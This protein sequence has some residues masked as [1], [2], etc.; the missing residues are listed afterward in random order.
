MPPAAEAA[1]RS[2]APVRRHRAQ[3]VR[4]ARMTSA[5]AVAVPGIARPRTRS[6]PP[7][8][9]SAPRPQPGIAESL[10]GVISSLPEHRF[11]DRLMRGRLWIGIVAFSLIGIVA[12][13]LAILDLNTGIGRSLAKVSRL[14]RENPAMSI[15]N[16]TAAAGENVEP[17]ATARGMEMSSVATM[18][19]LRSSPSNIERAAQILRE[20]A[21]NA[22]A[23][24]ATQSSTAASTPAE[25]TT[26]E[27]AA[28]SAPAPSQ[29]ENTASGTS[30]TAEATTV[31]TASESQA[32]TTPPA[33]PTNSPT[34]TESPATPASTT[35]TTD[36]GA[37]GGTQAGT[38]E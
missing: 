25:T 27:A 31:G 29:P 23:P 28:G 22:V 8:P 16:S 21:A 9:R 32:Q 33:Q 6:T 38:Q 10:L 15:E 13:Q 11:L 19:F 26:G 14:Q 34:T 2:I 3:G 30:T 1:A 4:A 37:G 12:M 17:K 35:A 24:A 36:T 5:G 7:R 20:P 18:Q